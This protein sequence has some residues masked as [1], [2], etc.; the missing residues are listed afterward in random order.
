MRSKTTRGEGLVPRWGVGPGHGRIRR[1]ISPYQATTPALHTLVRRPLP[2]GMT[3]CYES[4]SRTP[5]RSGMPL[6]RF[7]CASESHRSSVSSFRRRPESRGVGRG[8]CSAVEDFARRG[9]CPPLGRR[10]GVAESTVPIRRTKPQLQLF[11]PWCAGPCRHDRLLR[12]HVPDAD[13][14]CPYAASIVPPNPINLPYR[15]SGEGRNPEGWGEGNVV[16]SK[17]SRGEGLVPRRDRAWAR[18]N[19]PRGFA[20][21]NRNTGNS[22]LGVPA[23]AG[24][25][26]WYEARSHTPIR[27]RIPASQISFG[28][29]FPPHSQGVLINSIHLELL[30]EKS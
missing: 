4:M 26:D 12:K 13:P 25:S 9:A 18:Q 22:Y 2:A 7:D 19:P 24:M 14:G 10:R 15:H 28:V 27:G 29:P 11:I 5:T 20:V 21:Q 8:E 23:K 17:T 3:D 30:P 1:A 16:R 6:R